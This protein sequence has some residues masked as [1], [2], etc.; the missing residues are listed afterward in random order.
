[1]ALIKA[2][3][4]GIAAGYEL[5][6]TRTRAIMAPGVQIW[7]GAAL[8][9]DRLGIVR[10]LTPGKGRRF[11]GFAVESKRTAAEQTSEIIEIRTIG[12]F[13][14][15]VSGATGADIGAPVYAIDDNTFTIE[16]S[17]HAVPVGVLID[18]GN[19]GNTE[20]MLIR[21][22]AFAYALAREEARPDMSRRIRYV[23]IVIKGLWM[24]AKAALI[25]F[26]DRAIAACR[27]AARKLPAR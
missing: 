24:A 10:P 16:S 18:P 17:G 23:L 22:D 5:D 6:E 2:R 7:D 1:M 25:M 21:F 20:G 8:T 27:K 12:S 14:A 26:S 4:L 3:R 9:I 11:A 19:P 15:P 13:A